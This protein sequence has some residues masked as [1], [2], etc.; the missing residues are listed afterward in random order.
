MLYLALFVVGLL[1]GFLSGLI[2]IGGGVIYVF[3]LEIVFIE[4]GILPQEI[5]QFTIAN[6]MFAIFFT[7]LSANITLIKIKQF[8]LK[9]V[10]LIASGSIVTSLLVL[11]FVVN[12]SWFSKEKFNYILIVLLFYMLIRIFLE[13]QEIGFEKEIEQIKKPFWVISGMAAGCIASL[14]GLGG[15]I[16]MMPIFTSFL[17]LNIKKAKSISLGVICITALMITFSNFLEIPKSNVPTFSQGIIIFPVAL[18]LSL[19]IIS[20]PLGVK[21]A[22][23]WSSKT[24]KIIY[25]IFLTLFIVKKI[26]N[27]VFP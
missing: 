17:K 2:G 10:L 12:T 21:F 8:Y 1:G 20:A 23:K 27:I 14:S 18:L 3:I 26:V 13:K 5:P 16:V 11:E 9:T 22:Q 6:S 7:S 24:I 19:G 15:G 4:M 25:I